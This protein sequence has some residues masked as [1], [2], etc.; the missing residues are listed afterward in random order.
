MAWYD[1]EGRDEK[2]EMVRGTVE[3]GSE[4]EARSLLSHKA[5][6]DISI[7]KARPER[8]PPLHA[9]LRVSASDL[10]AF[11]RH[12]AAVSR[13]RLPLSPALREL[14]REIRKPALR[15]VLETMEGELRKGASLSQALGRYPALFP[16][17]YRSLVEAGEKSGNLSG[18]LDQ[19]GDHYQ[20]MLALRRRLG[21]FLIYPAFIIATVVA[22]FIF[23]GVFVV[24]TFAEMFKDM[25]IE[26]PFPTTVVMAVSGFIAKFWPYLAGLV[27]FLILLPILSPKDSA[28][29]RFLD[30]IWLRTPVWGRLL[31]HVSFSHFCRTLGTLLK[32]N[33]PL[34]Q[35]LG[36]VERTSL[37]NA[38]TQALKRMRV[39]VR[40]GR[41]LVDALIR[42]RI[43]PRTLIWM[44]S[45]AEQRGD[46][47]QVLLDLGD[48][49]H[50][51]VETDS[52]TIF[53][54]LEPLLIISLGIIVAATVIS[55]FL[56]LIRI[57]QNV[58]G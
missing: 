48:F 57:C 11:N 12:L 20:R 24:P 1:Y 21:E 19:I 35:A 47:P 36:L 10:I 9:P 6:G 55:M 38:L 42:E 50:E 34:L 30:R 56:P 40:E 45:S 46:L 52:R 22:V 15:R 32:G 43:F 27:A 18:V 51:E 26:L 58:M 5:L 8:I 49:Y 44:V 3:A 28:V 16:Q 13:A 29:R 25:G 2:G 39:E 33:V 14:S 37:T 54:L 53:F 4:E 23:L 31:T 7:R 17:F 41:S